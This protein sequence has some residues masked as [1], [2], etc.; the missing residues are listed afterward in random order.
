MYLVGW[1][2]TGALGMQGAAMSSEVV[3]VNLFRKG[4]EIRMY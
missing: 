1:S 2:Y 3:R 4:I